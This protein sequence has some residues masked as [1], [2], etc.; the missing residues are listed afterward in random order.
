MWAPSSPLISKEPV[1][2]TEARTWMCFADA[3]KAAFIG[4]V[5]GGT[6]KPTLT[7][8]L[9]SIFPHPR[10][11][12]WSLHAHSTSWP[13]LPCPDILDVFSKLT[14][15]WLHPHHEA[16]RDISNRRLPDVGPAASSGF[17]ICPGKGSRYIW[18]TLFLLAVLWDHF[19]PTQ[20]SRGCSL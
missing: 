1:T 10:C 17:S 7:S 5:L 16:Q 15:L 2:V 3:Q 14:V 18:S 19:S 13:H 4:V 20:S 12:A 8:L 9:I 6:G 11:W